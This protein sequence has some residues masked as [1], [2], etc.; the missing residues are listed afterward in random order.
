MTKFVERPR[1]LCALGGAVGTVNALPRAVAV[2]SA[3]G[4]ISAAA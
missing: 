1:Y 4:A 2:I 3:A